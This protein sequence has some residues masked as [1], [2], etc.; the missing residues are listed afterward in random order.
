MNNNPFKQLLQ[1]I[2]APSAILSDER[3]GFLLSLMV[4]ASY[5]IQADIVVAQAEI[6]YIDNFLRQHFGEEKRQKYGI[7]LYR[8]LAESRKYPTPLWQSKVRDCAY[9]LAMHNNT[10]ERLLLLAFLIKISKADNIV[11]ASE[12]STI[13]LVAQWLGVSA[14]AAMSID[15][16]KA[17]IITSWKL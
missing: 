3:D 15:T 1:D 12:V 7:V 17:E 11:T 10:E 4:L 13:A 9:S 5:T 6:E 2:D 14:E 16:L 8:L